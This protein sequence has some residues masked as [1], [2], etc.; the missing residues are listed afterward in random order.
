M[1][2]QSKV[3]ANRAYIKIGTVRIDVT[4]VA[5]RNQNYDL[6]PIISA[7]GGSDP[8][9]FKVRGRPMV[10]EFAVLEADE[11]NRKLVMEYDVSGN[12]LAVG[13]TMPTHEVSV[14]DPAANMEANSIILP[15]AVLQVTP[16]TE[17]GQGNRTITV[18][19]TATVKGGA[20]PWKIG[21]PGS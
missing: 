16:G 1:A 21:T 4:S 7:A 13:A 11:T 5:V 20:Q 8:H 18:T 10:I 6:V 14:V 12:P 9:G 3:S 19:A 2:D 15:E 17:D